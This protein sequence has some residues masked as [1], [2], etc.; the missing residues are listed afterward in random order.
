MRCEP[1]FRLLK[2]E[3]P[4]MWNEQYQEAFKKIKSYL[5]KLLILVPPVPEKPLLLYLTFTD[6]ALG[7]L[8]AQYL[9]ETRKKNAIYCISKKMLP[10]EEKYSPLKKICATLVWETRKLRH[11]TLAYR[12][13][14]IARM[15]PLKAIVDH[16]AHC[17]LEEAEEIQGDFLDEDIMGIEIQ[18]KWKINEERPMPYHDCLQKWASKFSMIQYQYVPRMQ[19]QITDALAAMAFMMDGSKEE[20]VRPIVLEQKEEPAYCMTK[21][22]DEGKSE[23]GEW[24]SEILL[25]LKDGTYLPYIDKNDQLSIQRLST[26]YII[27]GERLYGRSYD[28][29]YLLC[30][31]AKEPQTNGAFEAANKNIGR[32]LKKS[33][34]N[35]KD[36]HLQLPYALWGYRISIQSSTRATPYSLVYG[37]EVVLP[38]EM[39]VR[40]LRIVLESEI[41]EA[42]W[43]Q[44]RYNQLCMLDEKRLKALYHIQ[45]Y[46]RRLRK[47]FDKKVRTRDLKLGD[48]VLKEN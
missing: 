19:N 27:C 22:E 37:M 30:V 17:L 9:E 36:W 40:L 3:V 14:L 12:I 44:S 25:Y 10:Y 41:L 1:I 39:G 5:M 31:T 8:L 26:N 23:E 43:L 46:Q 47:A 6:I 42:D 21:E 45:E 7:A 29:I 33:T 4:T 2:K 13:L 38:I 15:D 28:G 35:Y 11:Y 16:V 20:R 48:L 32:I 24:Y 18:N 34:N